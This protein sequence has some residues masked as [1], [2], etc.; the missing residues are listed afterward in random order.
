MAVGTADVRAVIVPARTGL[1]DQLIPSWTGSRADA[2]RKALRMT[3]E[4]YADYLKV[5][6]RTVAY[7]KERPDTVPKQRMQSVLDT[8]LERAPAQAKALFDRLVNVARILT[9]WRRLNVDPPRLGFVV[10]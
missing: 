1:G 7:W 5:S 10:V 3:N 2:L 8:G 9:P 4:S 6:A